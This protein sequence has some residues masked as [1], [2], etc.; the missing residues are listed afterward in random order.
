MQS[1]RKFRTELSVCVQAHIP[2]DYTQ[3]AVIDS[4][5]RMNPR[6]MLPVAP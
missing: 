1:L 4:I 5:A 3:A 6:Q 2:L